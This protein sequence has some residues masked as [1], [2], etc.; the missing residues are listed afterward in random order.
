LINDSKKVLEESETLLSLQK[1]INYPKKFSTA[2]H[3]IISPGR[4]YVENGSCTYISHAFK[5][6]TIRWYLFS[7]LLVITNAR[8]Q[9]KKYVPTSS[10]LLGHVTIE[11]YDYAFEIIHCGT[12]KIWLATKTHED[13][14][15]LRKIF[16][17]CGM[18][19]RSSEAPVY[20]K[21]HE[22]ASRPLPLPPGKFTQ[23]FDGKNMDE[24]MGIV[25]TQVKQAP[26]PIDAPVKKRKSG[27]IISSPSNFRKGAG[28]GAPPPVPKK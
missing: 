28:V 5:S 7:D 23:S 1:K 15:R 3:P 17:D 27:L 25:Q 16:A 18:I 22:Y 13:R 14:N 19:D 6:S 8:N 21:L 2:E 20:S 24:I 26:T 12:D 11:G 10:A 9:L 4:K